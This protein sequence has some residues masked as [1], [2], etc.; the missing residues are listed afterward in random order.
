MEVLLP[1]TRLK[2]YE[3]L[4]IMIPIMSLT[5]YIYNATTIFL[6]LFFL[7]FELQNGFS[8]RIIDLYGVCWPEEHLNAIGNFLV[9]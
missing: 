2:S 3:L 5:D 8:I 6:Y 1:N 9:N 7:P 4:A